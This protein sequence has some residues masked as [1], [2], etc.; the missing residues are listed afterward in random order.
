MRLKRAQR[1]LSRRKKGS[2]RR[3][4]QAHRVG[5]IHRKVRDRRKGLLHQI[6]H[7][8]TARADVLKIETLNVQGM[9]KN[10]HLALLVADAGMGRLVTFCGY[11]ADWRGR[12]VEKV[13]PWFPSSQLC[14]MCGARYR[15]MKN[16]LVR[17]MRCDCGN[18]MGRDRNASVN[19]YSFVPAESGER[20]GLGRATCVE[21]GDQGSARKCHP[22]P[23]TEMRMRDFMA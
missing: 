17:T 13:D 12:T 1:I 7:V 10:H 9:V 23:V 21:I 20:L 5:V 4:A 15:K 3:R 22:V 2:A 19:I 11:K 8:L 18:V 16:L 14:R 6:S